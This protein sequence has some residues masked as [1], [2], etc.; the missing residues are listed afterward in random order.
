MDE[1][2]DGTIDSCEVC[3]SDSD[4]NHEFWQTDEEPGFEGQVVVVCGTCGAVYQ[5]GTG[6]LLIE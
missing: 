4:R 1:V 5:A 3:G 2:D 6:T